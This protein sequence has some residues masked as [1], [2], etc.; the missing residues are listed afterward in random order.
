MNKIEIYKELEKYGITPFKKDGTLFEGR[1]LIKYFEE[2]RKFY[3]SGEEFPIDLDTVYPL[4]YSTKGNA[5]NELK[6]N[7][8]EKIDYILLLP[9]HKQKIGSGGHNEIIYQLSVKCLEF[10]IARKNDEVFE[11]YRQV[12]HAANTCKGN[13][14]TFIK[15]RF[16]SLWGNN[17]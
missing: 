7:F 12:F 9:E 4:V 10:F 8:I 16:K 15:S 11:V 3:K 2:V 14:K 1:P 13:M 17:K 6:K 5:V